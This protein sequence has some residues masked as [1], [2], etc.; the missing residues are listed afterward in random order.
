VTQYK[1]GKDSLHAKGKQHYDRKWSNYGGQTELIFQ[2]KPKT[3]KKT[4]LRLECVSP[5][6]DLRECWLLR[7]ASILNWEKIRRERDK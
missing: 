4:V 2:K 5:T 7:N 6:A 1:K 3:T